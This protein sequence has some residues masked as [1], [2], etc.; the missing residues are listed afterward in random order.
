LQPTDFYKDFETILAEAL[1]WKN[2]FLDENTW[3]VKN[4]KRDFYE[5][6]IFMKI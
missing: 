5:L 4:E 6:L 1:L 2:E 3:F